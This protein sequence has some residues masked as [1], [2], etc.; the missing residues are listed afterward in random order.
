LRQISRKSYTQLT[1]GAG[2]RRS[3]LSERSEGLDGESKSPAISVARA[4]SRQSREIR[5]AIPVD[6]PVCASA[7]QP[8][9][10][11]RVA[12]VAST[13]PVSELIGANPINPAA[14]GFL[15]GLR[16][17]GY[18]QGQNLVMEWRSAEGRFERFPEIIRELISIKTDV[19]VTVT[20]PMTRAAKDVTRTVPIVMAGSGGPVEA[21][22][23]ES[24]ARP[25]G[26]ITGLANIS[27]AEIIA[28]RMQ[29]LKELLPGLSRVASLQS[30]AEALAGWEQSAAA[31]G[32]ELGVTCLNAEHTPTD[33]AAAFALIARE[34]PDALS[35]AH[36]AANLANRHLII[37]FAAKNRLP[38]MYGSREY[39]TAGGLIAYGTD[40]ADQFH[41][42]AGYV[43]RILKGAKPADMP[44][45]Q[46]TKWHLVVNLK[47]A[48]ALGLTIPPSLL[49]RADEVIE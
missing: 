35:V 8:P 47:T 4:Q 44:V 7:Q 42:A 5:P 16:S 46:P 1:E 26:N 40:I 13:S 2:G 15:R 18:V 20:D 28:K 43:D 32:R 24:L 25:G 33:Y 34:R 37:E 22:L 29:L 31:V 10:M 3:A 19:I 23:I 48:K 21:G 45:E 27:G 14:R 38:A 9:K 17:L 41:R 6:Q 36:S 39:V 12:F 30:K 11:H 49:A